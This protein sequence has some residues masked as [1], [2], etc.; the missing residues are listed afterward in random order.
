MRAYGRRKV[1]ALA[2]GLLAATVACS[3]TPDTTPTRAANVSGGPVTTTPTTSPEAP[4][5]TPDEAREI[6][7]EITATDDVLRTA[8]DLRFAVDLTRDGLRDLTSAAFD[9]S[10]GRPPLRTWGQPTMLVP[11]FPADA[12]SPWFSVLVPRDGQPTFLIF[13]KSTDKWRLSSAARLL[14][15]EKVPEVEVD[16][17]GYATAVPPD[18]KGVLIG[19]KFMAP[20]HATVAEAGSGGV[21][22]DLLSAGPYTT[23]I[24]SQIAEDRARWEQDGFTYDSI[25]S[26][27]EYPVFALRTKDGGALIQYTLTRTSTTTPATKSAESDGIP[28]PDDARW[29]ISAAKLRRS[30]KVSEI[31]Q[32]ATSVPPASA[33]TRA[34]VIAHDGGVTR[35][36]GD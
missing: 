9:S 23:D 30:L 12:T 28:V 3:G 11:R 16:A 31:H 34:E 14:P 32:Y 33:P 18:D 22:A 17:Q 35:A 15:G 10:G 1:L 8:G 20:L 4:A 26:A 25:L 6:F 27:G 5:I 21:A 36:S 29:A 13:A 19:P 2:A 24:A 7:T